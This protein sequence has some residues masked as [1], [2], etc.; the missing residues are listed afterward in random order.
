MQAAVSY[1]II[2]ITETW[3]KPHIKDAQVSIEGYSEPFRSDRRM[4]GRGGSCLYIKEDII[5][6]DSFKYDDDHCQIVGCSLDR[7]KTL[8]FSVYRPGDTPHNKFNDA[9]NFIQSFVDKIDDSWNI[10]ITGDFNFPNIH[11]ETMSIKSEDGCKTCAESLLTFMESNL[12][13]SC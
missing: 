1:S 7:L 2:S 12:L 11:W 13:S 8:V 3:L 9:V 10:I 5:V 6:S 4:R